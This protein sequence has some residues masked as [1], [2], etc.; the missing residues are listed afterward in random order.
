MLKTDLSS[1]ESV[2]HGPVV[3]GAAAHSLRD[4]M[5]ALG[6][7]ARSQGCLDTF[8]LT[9]CLKKVM[10]GS[11]IK[12]VE[13]KESNDKLWKELRGKHKESVEKA[14]NS[15]TSCNVTGVNGDISL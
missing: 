2:R 8:I 1:V 14:N 9:G 12:G 10:T 4:T 6:E 5:Y 3:L 15:M 13:Y 11:W 7:S